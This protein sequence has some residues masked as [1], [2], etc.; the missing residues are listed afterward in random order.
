MM[1]P[2]ELER[3]ALDRLPEL[4]VASGL[5]RATARIEGVEDET[6]PATALQAGIVV[7]L[8]LLRAEEAGTDQPFSTGAL[9]TRILGDLGNE[10]VT[11][12]E[13]GLALWAESRAG[14]SAIGEID[15]LIRRAT[16]RGFD[17]VTLEQL[18]WLASGL[19]ESSVLTGDTTN[20]LGKEIRAE[21]AG[22]INSSTG[23]AADVH[24]R[25]LGSA[26]P[27]SSQ[28]HLLHALCQTVRSGAE[29]LRDTAGKLASSL[30]TLQ[31]QDG[32]WPGLIDPARASAA[33]IYP[34][35]TVTQLAVAPIALRAASELGLPGNFDAAIG[36]G[37][38]WTGD[39]NAL[40][41]E[42]VHVEDARIDRGILP[43]RQPGA[44]GRGISSAARRITGQAAE[45]DA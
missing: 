36:N 41:R 35:L 23:L 4:Q 43:R 9:R 44:L 31:R 17:K 38:Y 15:G 24:G 16:V 8:G 3:I 42:L 6:E 39:G 30:L 33:V 12:G 18:A 1:E 22:R 10:S 45:P 21:I 26:V 27:V 19:S 11:P 13:L 2:R 28:F 32:A 40:G 14:G 37:I 7:L 5:F 34:V 29:D 25:R 20:S